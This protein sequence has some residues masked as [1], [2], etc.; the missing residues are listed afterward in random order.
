MHIKFLTFSDISIAVLLLSSIQLPPS[1][2]VNLTCYL[3]YS[4]WPIKGHNISSFSSASFCSQSCSTFMHQH[5]VVPYNWNIHILLLQLYPFG[6][7][8]MSGECFGPL[9]IISNKLHTYVLDTC[10]AQPRCSLTNSPFNLYSFRG[11]LWSTLNCW[12]YTNQQTG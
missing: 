9:F 6:K 10:F 1:L 5:L 7:V 11:G 3:N 4:P 8:E 2:R 12:S